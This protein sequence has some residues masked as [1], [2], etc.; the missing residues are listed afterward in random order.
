MKTSTLRNA[1]SIA[2]LVTAIGI[3]ERAMAQDTTTD[4]ATQGSAP[5][6]QAPA[7][8]PPKK[9]TDKSAAPAATNLP[10][11]TV[12]GTR[13]R[14]GSTPSP[15]ITIGSEQIRQEGFADLGEVIRS[16]PQNFSGG[17]NPGVAAGAATGGPSNQ[18]VTGGSGLNLRGL[19]PDATLTLL[20][21]RRMS[22]GGFSQAVDVSAIPVEAVERMEIVPD[23][24]SAIYGSDAVGGVA[25]VILKRDFEG[26]T[27]GARYGD[28]TEGG[29]STHEYSATAG[30]TWATGGLIVAGKKSANDPIR[31]DQRDYTRSMYRPSTLWQGNDLR[32]GL[33]SLH[34]S[35]GD[36]AELHLDAL[37][38]T[39]DIQTDM[40]YASV[41][42]P[43]RAQTHST[44]VAPGVDLWLGGDWTLTLNGA[45]GNDKTSFAQPTVSSATGTVASDGR[46]AYSN[47]SRTYEIGAEG[48]LFTL[49]GGEARLA[50]GAGYRRNHFLDQSLTRHTIAADGDQSSRFAYAELN[51]PLVGPEQGVGGVD[52]LAL[53]GA[54]R[55]EDG[56][57][58]TV[59]TPKIGVIYAPST[60]LSLKASWGKSFKAP[61]LSQ[62][63]STQ[64][65]VYYTAATFGGAGYPAD[66]A[67]LWLSGGSADLRPERARTWSTSLA[68]HPAAL[69]RLETELIWFD[70]D[71]TQRI[72]QPIT[73]YDVLGNPGYADFVDYQPSADAQATA[74]AGASN[75]YNYVGTPY[76]ASKVVAIID[77]RYVNA[78]RQRIKGV[79]LSG[80]YRFH[81]GA[82]RLTVRG[83]ASWLD[84]TQALTTTQTP[85]DLAG[86]LFH[87]AKT[88]TRLGAVWSQ[89]GISASLFGNYK[90]G[91][92]D[93]VHGTKGASFTTFDTTLRYD[94]GK[95]DD[96]LADMSFELAAQNLLDRAPPLY[97]AASLTYAPYDST[98]YSAMGRFLSLSVTKHW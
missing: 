70:I 16:V 73:A 31:S 51:L 44:L 79:D 84:S 87:P 2:L 69:P 95:R 74:L 75:F 39:R 82:G 3:G 64:A 62:R 29:L 78:S 67:V 8:T 98:N 56:D 81:L 10:T 45:V 4:T 28:A 36:A 49:P 65:A 42:Y 40:A 60:D 23:G 1:I 68:F 57:Y 14:G 18:N 6:T 46:G 96:M 61:T 11:V 20:N 88:S 54:V 72:L 41:Y 52:R 83:S 86:T 94:T 35:L 90:S 80:S 9:S 59:T 27:V 97:V 93:T 71:Y 91:V 25:N 47:K 34:Q 19:G 37:G 43:Y 89:G 48:P 92:T 22:Y 26:V 85:Y 17:Q 38:S 33:L 66:A 30:T 76:D 77:G 21:G 53:T 15:V 55:T 50:T 58:G 5:V 32:S 13:I 7:K 24:A 12:T 63:Y